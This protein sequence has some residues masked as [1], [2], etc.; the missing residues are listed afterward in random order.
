[1]TFGSVFGQAFHSVWQQY[2]GR[3]ITVRKSGILTLIGIT[4]GSFFPFFRVPLFKKGRWF[5]VGAF[6]GVVFVVRSFTLVLLT[7]VSKRNLSRRLFCGGKDCHK[8]IT[9]INSPVTGVS[10]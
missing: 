1:M 6:A 4:D 7:S 10:G 5:K 2:I 3:F 8:K 9:S